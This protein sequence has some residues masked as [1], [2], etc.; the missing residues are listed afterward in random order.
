MAT[1]Y[2]DHVVIQCTKCGFRMPVSVA[3]LQ[4]LNNIYCCNC[5]YDMAF[6][7]GGWTE[8]DKESYDRIGKG[9]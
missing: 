7:I 8:E 4:Y 5:N 6:I 9:Y 1:I 3:V 2:K